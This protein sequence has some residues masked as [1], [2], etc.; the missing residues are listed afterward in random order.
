M[1]NVILVTTMWGKLVDKEE[2]EQ[3][4]AELKGDFWGDMVACG[5]KTA[6]FDKTDKSAWRIVDSL[7]GKDRAK[8]LLSTEMVDDKLQLPETQAGI[9]L[10][11]ELEKL[12]RDRQR[13]VHKLARQVKQY[14]NDLEIQE[15]N[16]QTAAEIEDKI[17]K[18]A[19]QLQKMKV[20]FTRKVRLF[21]MSRRN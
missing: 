3:R 5:C 15:L 20:P 1:P 4:E 7:A 21:F 17:R 18:T 14:P 9:A 10:N 8:V 19:D 13:A 12:I 16:Q 6:R 2:G 11:K